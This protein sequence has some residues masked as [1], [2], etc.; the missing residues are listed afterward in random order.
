MGMGSFTFS[1]TSG[2]CWALADNCSI[3]ELHTYHCYHTGS[4]RRHPETME[5][6]EIGLDDPKG[7]LIWTVHF[8]RATLKRLCGGRWGKG[9]SNTWCMGIFSSQTGANQSL[10]RQSA[11]MIILINWSSLFA[12]SKIR[13]ILKCCYSH[14]ALLYLAA[15]H[16]TEITHICMHTRTLSH[17]WSP[18]CFKTPHEKC[19]C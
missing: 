4:L 7:Q 16:K 14:K 19:P 11:V 15:A 12:S 6:V 8:L 13:L 18:L 3:V 9:P 2:T 5:E 1:A 17:L 10:K